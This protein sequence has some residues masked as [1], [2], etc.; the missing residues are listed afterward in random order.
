MET[1]Y[2]TP[3]PLTTLNKKSQEITQIQAK[4]QKQISNHTITHSKQSQMAQIQHR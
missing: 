4:T 1:P 3:T 2:T